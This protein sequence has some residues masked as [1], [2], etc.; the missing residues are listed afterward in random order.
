MSLSVVTVMQAIADLTISGV[1]TK[2][3]SPPEQIPSDNLP[4]S[5][6]R[7]PTDETLPMTIEGEGGWDNVACELV[8]LL[9]ATEQ[10]TWPTNF[11]ETAQMMDA[12]AT[13]FRNV[14]RGTIFQSHI[15]WTLMGGVVQL[16]NKRYWSV[17]CRLSGTG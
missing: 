2:A 15:T 11:L 13:A 6:V 16:G 1:K 12:A 5:F 9:E 3:S 17:V 4:L 8:I 10:N 14:V 7:L